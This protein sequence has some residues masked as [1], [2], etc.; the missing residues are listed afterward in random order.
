MWCWETGSYLEGVKASGRYTPNPALDLS[1][2]LVEGGHSGCVSVP[3][4]LR[5][6][7]GAS[8]FLQVGLRNRQWVPELEDP[9]KGGDI[10]ECLET[11]H[12]QPGM[13]R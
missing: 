9:G 1:L 10:G 12:Y 7:R 11:A 4:A 6:G 13:W 5:A 2:L 8:P 3:K